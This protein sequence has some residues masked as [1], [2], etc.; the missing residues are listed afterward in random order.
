M[1][2]LILAKIA[3]LCSDFVFYNR[4][5]DEE[6]S[7]DQLKEAVRNGDISIDEMVAEFKKHLTEN[8]IH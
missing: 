2:Q 6:L 1:K 4:K 3:D 7:S 8:L 5:S